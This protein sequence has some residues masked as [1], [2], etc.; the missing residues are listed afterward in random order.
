MTCKQANLNTTH[1]C[2][3]HGLRYKC[4]DCATDAFTDGR[5]ES[6]RAELREA[7]WNVTRASDFD[8]ARAIADFAL[9]R[10]RK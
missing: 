5:I 3:K 8:E 7:L 10:G 2:E 9:T 6:D 1:Y 4:P